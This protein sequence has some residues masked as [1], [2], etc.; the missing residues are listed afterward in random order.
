MNR[1]A[2]YF[3]V[4]LAL[5]LMGGTFLTAPRPAHA[6][7]NIEG[8]MTDDRTVKPG[9]KYEGLI[10]VRNTTSR[11]QQVRIYQTDY[12]FFADGTNK[13][14]EPGS[15]PR[16]NASWIEVSP[17]D[18]T[19]QPGQKVPVK[20]VVRVPEGDAVAGSHWS[21]IMIE[22]VRQVEVPRKEESD[23]PVITT[24]VRVRHGYQVA[25]HVGEASKR[26]L[27][28]EGVALN[29][30]EKTPA[31]LQVDVAATG[32]AMLRPEAWI[33]LFTSE[34]APKDRVEGQK[35]RIYPGTSVRYRFDLSHLPS[36]TYQALVLV[37]TG[38]EDI[39]G[40]KYMLDL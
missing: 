7:I 39:V 29:K 14:G 20:Y 35:Y 18:L 16:S 22:G 30:G 27:E 24:Q 25:T 17:S 11:P 34:G 37:D 40:A 8:K 38:E 3:P 23:K 28:F 15:T 4:L 5:L 12:L 2:S 13:Y 6:Q 9:A 21:M 32:N 33:E 31:S 10:H 36:G 26:L 1:N 19:I